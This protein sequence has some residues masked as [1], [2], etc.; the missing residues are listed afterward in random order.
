ML[1]GWRAARALAFVVFVTYVFGTVL[2]LR[3][4]VYNV[5]TGGKFLSVVDGTRPGKLVMRSNNPTKWSISPLS[6]DGRL[7]SLA[8]YSGSSKDAAPGA[9][10][11]RQASCSS[12][13]VKLSTR[14]QTSWRLRYHYVKNRKSVYTFVASEKSAANCSRILSGSGQAPSIVSTNRARNTKWKLRLV[15]Y[16]PLPGPHPG[17][18]T[19]APV[20]PQAP[21]VDWNVSSTTAFFNETVESF[22]AEDEQNL[23]LTLLTVANF[24]N[25]PK[26]MVSSVVSMTSAATVLSLRESQQGIFVNATMSYSTSSASEVEQGLRGME[27]LNSA[28][29]EG[30]A[31]IVAIN[32][33]IAVNNSSLSPPPLPSPS[34]PLPSPPPPPSSPPPPPP[35]FV[36]PATNAAPPTISSVVLKTGAES[37]TVVVTWS[38]GAQSVPAASDP[39]FSVTCVP[40]GNGCP[41]NPSYTLSRPAGSTTTDVGS[42]VS[43]TAYDCYVIAKNWDGSKVCSTSSSI[44]TASFYL[45][46]NGVTVKCPNAAVGSTGTVNSVTYTKRSRSDLLTLIQGTNW[47]LLVTSCTSGITDMSNLFDRNGGPSN[48]RT[49][50][51]DISTWDTSAVTTMASMFKDQTYFDQD[52]SSWDVSLVTSLDS[53]VCNSTHT[54]CSRVVSLSLTRLLTHKHLPLSVQRRQ[55]V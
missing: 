19:P 24:P 13:Q 49:F 35:T 46:P 28:S 15:K 30:M 55:Q 22:D 9:L 31:S 44:T 5:E 53:A 29:L 51:E 45:D 8:P 10:S 36:V 52:I 47:P 12:R 32:G 7:V 37:D 48:D 54:L 33:T 6:I 17:E 20:N 2:A 18:N 26:C 16:L 42:L 50:N 39:S 41:S 1:H 11:Y 34:P 14:G 4:G 25:S 27:N 43:G 38:P 23:C 40:T 21:L 3:A